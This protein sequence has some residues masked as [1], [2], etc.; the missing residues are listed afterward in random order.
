MPRRD[1]PGRTKKQC[2]PHRFEKNL[3]GFHTINK[4][5]DNST[6]SGAG[7]S[8][9][10]AAAPPRALPHSL[11]HCQCKFHWHWQWHAAARRRRR[12]RRRRAGGAAAGA[13]KLRVAREHRPAAGLRVVARA[14]AAGARTLHQPNQAHTMRASDVTVAR[15]QVQGLSANG[16][17]IG[18]HVVV[19]QHMRRTREPFYKLHVIPP[20]TIT[21]FP[22]GP[23]AKPRT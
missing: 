9:R 16:L 22:A 11:W 2:S 3:Q 12:R 14:C 18:G 20:R 15:W 1:P 4:P 21:C 6:A 19:W 23:Q 17:I 7:W 5:F 10:L 8:G 13:K